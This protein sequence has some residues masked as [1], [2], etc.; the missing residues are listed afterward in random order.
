MFLESLNPRATHFLSCL[1]NT[2]CIKYPLNNVSYEM[3][4]NFIAFIRHVTK[5]TYANNL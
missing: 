1:L 4:I 5:V 3:S 2:A